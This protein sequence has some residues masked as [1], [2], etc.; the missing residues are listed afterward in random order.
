MVL[1]LIKRY[2]LALQRYKWAGIA[3]FLGVLGASSI[4]A[5]QP[6][7]EEQF[8]SEGVLVQNAPVVSFTAT[9]VEL[10][11]RG[12]GIITEDFLLADILLAQV[13][14]QLN[15]QGF[16]V[17]PSKIRQNTNIDIS[18]GDETLQ[19]VTV[20]YVTENPDEAEAVLTVLF[21]GMV[22]L[23][24]VTNRARL[25]EIVKAL[26]ERL[27]EVEEE[28]RQAEQALEDYDRNEGPA[29]QAARDGSLLS[30]I[31]GSENQFRQN[32]IALAGIAAQ[33]QSLEQRLGLSAD[34]A[35]T[36]SA[37]SADPIVA[38]LRARIHETETQME[39]LS[40]S[41][42]AQHPTMVE[43]QDNLIAYNNLLQDRAREVIGG[44]GQLR[45]LPG[46]SNAVR[47][48]SNLDPARAAL[49]NQLVE[50]STQRDALQQQQQ[51]LIQSVLQMREEYRQLPNKQL[52]RDRLAQQA[53]LKKAL[54]DQ[55]QAKRIDAQAAEAE[56]VSSLSIAN[57]PATAPIPVETNNPV[58]VLLIGAFLGVVVGG[59]IVYLLDML[60][61]TI[62][63][64]EDL[65][66]LFEDQ[67]VPLLGLIPEMPSQRGRLAFALI[68][69][70]D[71]ACNDIY[72]RLRTNLQFS[73]IQL[74]DGTVPK[75][76]LITSTRNQEGKT[77][78]AFNLGIASARA[79]RRTLVLEMDLR[80]PS[81]A[82][83]LG[84]KPDEQAIL[85]PLR[86]YSGHLSDPV[87]M[88]P[89]IENLYICPSVGPQR[90]PAAILDSSE[91][92]RFLKDIKARFDFIILDVP[93]LTSSN[94]AMLLEPKTDGMIVVSRP[95]FT[96]KPVLT[97]ALE[98][99]EENE[100][101]R[102][103]GAVINSAKIPIAEAQRKEE[104]FTTR[105]D[106]D[107]EIEDVVAGDV[108]VLSSIDF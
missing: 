26:N 60:D 40:E 7:P 28:L 94:D 6:P 68:T 63:T 29:I 104:E 17:Q 14:E 18:T 53:A 10:Q 39:L 85:E 19:Q 83:R 61:S 44:S 22:E 56:T 87:K 105:N 58:M 101:I 103:L 52:N 99:I 77:T 106:S 27:P 8:K 71:H 78:T 80:A 37:L 24:R 47:Q 9:G 86:Y 54:Y 50:L 76:I 4:V 46:G 65:D 96:E 107:D 74:S 57:L 90:N 25:G 35:Y 30:S 92:S 45:A 69:D 13:S 67:D 64:Y 41:L 97:T 5:I 70:P 100:D 79:G 82:Q 55:I 11:Q 72:E 102:I 21:N 62:R 1:P 12:Q 20:S 31:S 43:L 49:A 89:S 59:A 15:Q 84:I 3:S 38:Q 73:G 34:E 32:Q 23:S 48:N 33:M 81:Q 66:K 51:A 108:P 91:I 16:E 95:D 88:V 42:R 93:H 98:Q 36:S 2:V 75:V